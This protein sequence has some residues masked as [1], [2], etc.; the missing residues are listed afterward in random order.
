MGYRQALPQTI[1]LTCITDGGMETVLTFQRGIDLPCFA[2]FP[3]LESDTGTSELL[4]YFEPYALIALERGIGLVL[5]TPT[6]RANADWG[7]RL[8]YDAERLA[9]ANRK[10]VRLIEQIGRA[11]CRERV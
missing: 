1:G 4:S 10:A 7:R 9:D 6:W 3:L 8:D 2:A 5:D 11:S